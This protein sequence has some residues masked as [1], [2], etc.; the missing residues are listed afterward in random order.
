MQHGVDID[1]ILVKDMLKGINEHKNVFHV[2]FMIL[3]GYMLGIMGGGGGGHLS[4]TRCPLNQTIFK[5]HVF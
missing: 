2:T 3:K 1:L 5:K 4:K